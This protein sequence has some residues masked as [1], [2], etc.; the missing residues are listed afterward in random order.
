MPLNINGATFITSDEL[1]Q[2]LNISRQTLWRWRQ[3]GDV[4]TGHRY[5]GRQVVFTSD[6]ADV[7]REYAR[8]IDPIGSDTAKQ[9]RLFSTSRQ[10]RRKT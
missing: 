5:R 2:E 10:S 9:L 3:S 4:P 1:A 6:E 7:I 8:R